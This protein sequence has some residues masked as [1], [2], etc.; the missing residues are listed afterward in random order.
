MIAVLALVVGL[1]AGLG[2][3][4]LTEARTTDEH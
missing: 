1:V 2:A 3:L 4:T